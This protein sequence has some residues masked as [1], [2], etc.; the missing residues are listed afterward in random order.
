MQNF[1]S[2]SA[3]V[4]FDHNVVAGLARGLMESG[5]VEGYASRCFD[6]VR[7][8]VIHSADTDSDIVSCCASEIA[9][10]RVGLCYAKSHLLVALL[11]AGNIPSGFSYQRLAMDSGS[12]CLHGLVSVW[13]EQVG[14]FRVDPRG[15]AR[16]AMARFSPPHD[17]LVYRAE[18]LGERDVP[19]VFAEPLPSVLLALSRFTS[20]RGLMLNLPDEV[21]A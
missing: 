19:G 3:I 13:D 18:A 5:S 16:G 6:W 2:A 12:F 14:W 17:A 8:E 7:D 10:S 4:D 20:M 15:G 1:L 9:V 21:V 11:R